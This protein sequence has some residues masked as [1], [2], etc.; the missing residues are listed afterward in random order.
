MPE[1]AGAFLLAPVAQL[2]EQRSFKPWVLGPSP[3]GGTAKG[4]GMDMLIAII[5]SRV[6][7]AAC[8]IALWLMP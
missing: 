6:A 4:G 5:G 2:A 3:S 7:S 1:G 8:L